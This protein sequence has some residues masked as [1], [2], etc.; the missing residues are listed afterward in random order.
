MKQ[1]TVTS[2]LR[3]LEFTPKQIKRIFNSLHYNGFKSTDILDVEI[4][5]DFRN[6]DWVRFYINNEYGEIMEYNYAYM[7]R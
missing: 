5:R 6:E 7:T 3:N 1:E 2:K 4:H